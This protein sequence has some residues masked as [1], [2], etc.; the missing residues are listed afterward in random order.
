V[1]NLQP[2]ERVLL[3]GVGTGADLRLLPEG[4]WANGIDLSK[5]MLA[6]ANAKL[7][8]L[9]CEVALIRGDAQCLPLYKYVFDCAILNL[10]L[11]VVPNGAA[12]LQETMRAVKPGGRIVIFDKFLPDDERLTLSR[13]LLN[14]IT[15][16]FGTDITRR[17]IDIMTGIRCT[18]THDEP[19]LLN[20]AYRIILLE[21]FHSG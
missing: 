8:S 16:F 10:I 3:M 11:S 4:I 1:L 2:G 19:S 15:M 7:P 20:G 9:K 21:K 5:E 17:L 13:R 18:K 14:L 6:R 12:C